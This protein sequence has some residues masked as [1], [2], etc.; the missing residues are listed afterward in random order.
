MKSVQLDDDVDKNNN[1]PKLEFLEKALIRGEKLPS[2]Y[3]KPT[4]QSV[5]ERKC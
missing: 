4:F 5:F 2:R 3:E 1:K